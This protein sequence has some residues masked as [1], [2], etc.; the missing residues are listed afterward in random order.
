MNKNEA[1]LKL[2]N[3]LSIEDTAK[4][5]EVSRATLYRWIDDEAMHFPRP[6]R[7]GNRVGF[8]EDEVRM[9]MKIIQG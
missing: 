5:L 9:W 2:A 6:V 3:L 1:L 7:N 4:M 8:K